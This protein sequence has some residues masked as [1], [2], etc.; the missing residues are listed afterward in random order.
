MK[1]DILLTLARF[2]LSCCF[3][4]SGVNHVARA[5]SYR[6]EYSTLVS[7]FGQNVVGTTLKLTNTHI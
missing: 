7:K 3:I 1:S 6:S 4:C 2:F 5:A